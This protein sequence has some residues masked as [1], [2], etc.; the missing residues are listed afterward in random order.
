MYKSYNCNTNDKPKL[1]LR[2]RLSLPRHVAD[3]PCIHSTNSR[4]ALMSSCCSRLI[5]ISEGCQIQIFLL[6]MIHLFSWCIPDKYFI[7]SFGLP[8]ISDGITELSARAIKKN[9]QF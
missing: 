8:S 9:K 4:V 1:A 7:Y 3:N 2:R 6:D 5:A